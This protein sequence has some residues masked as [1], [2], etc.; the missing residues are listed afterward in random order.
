[1][2]SV[3]PSLFSLQFSSMC[4]ITP[5]SPDDGPDA[6]AGSLGSLFSSRL[7]LRVLSETY[8]FPLFQA[9]DRAGATRLPFAV[10]NRSLLSHAISLPFSD[11]LETSSIS[12]SAYQR[13][14][15]TIADA[16]P[17]APVICKTTYSP[18]TDGLGDVDRE[19]MYH[20]VPT[21]SHQAVDEQMRSSFLR[22]VRQSRECGVTIDRSTSSEALSQFY[23][24]H[25][26]LRF[27]KFGIIPQPKSFFES[28]RTVFL[29]Q[30]RG[31]VLRAHRRGRVIGAFLIL[32]HGSMLYYKFGASAVDALDYRPNNLLFH[33]LLH[34]AVD[35]DMKAVDLGLA[36]TS[37]EYAGLRRFKESFGGRPHPVTQFRIDPPGYDVER[38]RELQNVF[39]QVTDAVVEHDANPDVTDA[40]SQALY[41]YFA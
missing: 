12:V 28:I 32:Q 30:E 4:T 10:P 8:G 13:L 27:G 36:G 38:E 26:S 33:T 34:S 15:H 37:D 16:Y 11:Y 19:A 14:L 22:N 9:V 1:M 40:V 21:S 5:Y 29:K 3:L 20:R 2:H 6:D 35:R 23:R 39:G 31:F 24:L 7:W 18:S 41:P 17:T 25:R